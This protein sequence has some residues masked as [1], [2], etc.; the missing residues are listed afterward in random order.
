M[1]NFCTEE[2]PFSAQTQIKYWL[3]N[4]RNGHVCS[5]RTA[6]AFPVVRS[7][8]R[9]YVC[10]SQANTCV[11][12]V[13]FP[14]KSY[15]IDYTRGFTHAIFLLLCEGEGAGGWGDGRRE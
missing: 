6:D 3:S 12:G 13:N 7:D 14:I 5:L 10:C 2:F 9:K 15:R 1:H 4:Q 11:P 8:D